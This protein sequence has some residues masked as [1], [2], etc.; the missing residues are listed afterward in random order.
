LNP[1]LSHPRSALVALLLLL[2]AGNSGCS[3]RVESGSNVAGSGGA[4]GSSAT[5]GTG[6]STIASAPCDNADATDFAELTAP[7]GEGFYEAAIAATATEVGLVY[8]RWIEE[9][10]DILVYFQR[11]SLDGA[12][13]GDPVVLHTYNENAGQYAANGFYGRPTIATD[14]SR[15]VACWGEAYQV[16]CAA[17]TAGSGE[18]SFHLIVPGNNVSAFAPNVTFGPSGFRVF[19]LG[20]A[21][22]PT[23]VALD[24]QASPT[25]LT[26]TVPVAAL[27]AVATDA[28]YVGGARG[29]VEAFRLGPDLQ[30]V[31]DPI[32]L[33]NVATGIAWLGD[34]VSVVGGFAE[35][36]IDAAGKAKSVILVTGDEP[37]GMAVAPWK[38]GAGVVWSS[39]DRHLRLSVVS[40]SSEPGPILDVG[41][42]EDQSVPSIAAVPDGLLV[43]SPRPEGAHEIFYGKAYPRLRITHVKIP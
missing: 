33:P 19:Y 38:G 2:A 27:M 12:A 42:S 11:F 6:G 28:G 29:S 14:G 8:S 39:M 40:P 43:A 31:G 17:V 3:G 9:T 25:G 36:R 23:T 15:F 37:Q 21:V 24:Q 10:R 41:C 35:T 5:G 7:D 18:A 20:P 4:G 1:F 32:E 13:L 30:P 22:T 34:A 26:V 16:G